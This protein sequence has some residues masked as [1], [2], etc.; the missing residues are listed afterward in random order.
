MDV[1]IHDADLV[2]AANRYFLFHCDAYGLSV[3]APK[4]CFACPDSVSR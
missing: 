3:F 4:V 1:R 2:I